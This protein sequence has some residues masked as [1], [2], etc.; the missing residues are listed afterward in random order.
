MGMSEAMPLYGALTQ[1][2]CPPALPPVRTA[3]LAFAA[4]LTVSVAGGV[5]CIKLYK[6]NLRDLARYARARR[7]YEA[8]R[9]AAPAPPTDTTTTTT[10]TTTGETTT[11]SSTTTTTSNN[12]T[13]SSSSPR[14]PPSSSSGSSSAVPA[15]PPSPPVHKEW[16]KFAH[17]G[18][19]LYSYGLVMGG[20]L[21]LMRHEA[22]YDDA[23]VFDGSGW[24]WDWDWTAVVGKVA[25]W[26]WLD[27]GIAGV[28]SLGAAPVELDLEVAG[29]A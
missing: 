11:G 24:G 2:V 14:K 22:G 21:A 25:S 16:L 13:S 8:S 5:I 15:L 20:A 12:S 6:A 9:A 7:A 19:M 23:P 4:V 17:A 10:T 26:R 27:V 28:C 29:F 18:F 3:A 1:V